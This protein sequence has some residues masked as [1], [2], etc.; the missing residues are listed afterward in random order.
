MNLKH[1][2][3]ELNKTN[4]RLVPLFS[5]S[6]SRVNNNSIRSN[7]IA[8]ISARGRKSVSGPNS[9]GINPPE[10][11]QRLSL[12]AHKA[13]KEQREHTNNHTHKVKTSKYLS[14]LRRRSN[15]NRRISNFWALRQIQAQ[16]S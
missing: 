4:R 14:N 11:R 13:E 1:S 7:Q 6:E 9:G 3:D 5:P 15:E 2:T 8:D 10:E 16:K 12:Q